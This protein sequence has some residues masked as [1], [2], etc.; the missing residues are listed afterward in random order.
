MWNWVNVP[1]FCILFSWRLSWTAISYLEKDNNL[2]TEIF[3][4]NYVSLILFIFCCV[5]TDK[6]PG[7]FQQQ[8]FHMQWRYNFYLSYVKI[9]KKILTCLS[10]LLQS[11]PIGNYPH[12]SA[13]FLNWFLT[14]FKGQLLNCMCLI[15]ITFRIQINAT[16]FS[17]LGCALD[18]S[19]Y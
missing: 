5:D 19:I 1:P 7:F 13:F 15:A 6:I 9:I 10:W 3:E 16:N 2:Q 14:C 8:K 18:F 11:Q 4:W 12:S 17:I